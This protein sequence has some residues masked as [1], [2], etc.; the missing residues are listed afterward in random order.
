LD[1]KSCVSYSRNSLTSTSTENDRPPPPNDQKRNGDKEDRRGKS[2]R[3]HHRCRSYSSASAYCSRPAY[4]RGNEAALCSS[5]FAQGTIITLVF[6]MA[7]WFVFIHIFK[8]N[9]K[10]CSLV[11]M[12][13]LYVMDWYNRTMQS[14][15]FP[16]PSY[17]HLADPTNQPLSEANDLPPDPEKM[18]ELLDPYWIPTNQND[19]PPLSFNCPSNTLASL[20]AGF[21]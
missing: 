19:V 10:N 3:A 16:G 7:L 9:H 1:N 4:C 21:G 12:C 20:V 6:I 17:V 13:T 18:I 5:K 2:P 14:K 11:T 8:I 15:Y